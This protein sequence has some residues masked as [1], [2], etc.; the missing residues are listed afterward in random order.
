MAGTDRVLS[1]IPGFDQVSNGG[2]VKGSSVL[3]SGEAG[4]GKTIFSLQFLNA[5]ALEGEPALYVT[6]ED[7]DIDLLWNMKSFGW[8]F[9]TLD[10][11]N[12]FHPFKLDM[13]QRCDDFVKIDETVSKLDEVI[14]QTGA[15][16]V[17][18]DS[19][20]AFALYTG[21]SQKIRYLIH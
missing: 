19:I 18:I 16:R 17:V 8:D 15:K 10:E 14:A 7:P 1:G 13:F 4:S 6:V 5:G 12:L 9:I 20:T 21:D 11:K 3:V 2:F